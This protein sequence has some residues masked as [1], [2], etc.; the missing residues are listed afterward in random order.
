METNIELTGELGVVDSRPPT[1]ESK[2]PP[3]ESKPPTEETTSSTEHTSTTDQTTTSEQ[4]EQKEISAVVPA[5]T[6]GNTQVPIK[7]ETQTI[8]YFPKTNEQTEP[9]FVTWVGI[10]LVIAVI[11]YQIIDRK[12]GK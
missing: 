8:E 2:P 4:R 7:V 12:M 9:L 5:D 3:D 1:E 6:Q 10:F 11:S